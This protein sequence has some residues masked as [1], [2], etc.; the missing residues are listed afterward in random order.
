MLGIRGEALG[1]K[2]TKQ[3]ED[4]LTFKESC[5]LSLFKQTLK[6]NSRA[7]FLF[8]FFFWVLSGHILGAEEYF[9]YLADILGLSLELLNS[10]VYQE[11]PII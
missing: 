9:I 8:L 10:Y 7:Q 6:V 1:I 2:S 5:I 3:R 4:Y 11:T